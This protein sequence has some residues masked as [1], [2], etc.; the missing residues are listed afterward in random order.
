MTFLSTE[1]LEK[2]DNSPSHMNELGSFVF[3]RTYSR[4]LP[5]LGRRETWKEAVARA[6]NYNIGIAKRHF[7]KI[8]FPS[9]VELMS[10]EA[11]AL[12]DNIFNLRQFLSGRT[13]W[14]GGA[15]SSV[16]DKYPLSNFNCAFI[17]IEKWEDLCELFYLLLVGTGVGFSARTKNVA[18]MNH[19][20]N[21]LN[22]EHAPY[23]P[24]AKEHR[25]ENT[26]LNVLENGYAKMYIG[27]S[28]E[29][30]VEGLRYYFQVLQGDYDI[31]TLKISYNSVR[32]AGEELKT[33]GGR[34]SGYET[35]R[36]MFEGIN[37]TIKGELDALLDIPEKIGEASVMRPV[38]V[39]DMA[40]LIGYNVV[41]GGVRRTAEITLFDSDDMEVLLAKY[42]INDIYDEKAHLEVIN[43]LASRGYKEWATK[44]ATLDV[45]VPN[46]RPLHHRRMSNNSVVFESKPE[47]DFLDLVFTIMRTEGEPGFV[48]LE[49]AKRRRPNAKGLNPCAR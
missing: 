27:D 9:N 29:G 8:G 32:P 24:I 41:A 44:L 42:G 18:Q 38:H 35:L 39:M 37:K 15:A 19:L 43:A 31:H 36:D 5:E 2:Y 11:E 30:W 45:G 23:E 40:N 17:E 13:H 33:F 26:Q 49:E 21:N 48:N 22:V 3:Y 6:V 16:A 34:A 46:V 25:I 20:R 7:D 47:R 1:F 14:V 4:Y 10:K 28:K 12:F